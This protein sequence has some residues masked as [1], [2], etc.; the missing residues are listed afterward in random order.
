MAYGSPASLDEVEG[1]YTHIRRGNAPTAEQLADLVGRYQ[2]IGGVSTLRARTE[3]QCS[4][5]QAALDTMAPGA[6]EV[7]LGMKHA[8]PLIEDAID[9]IADDDFERVVAAVLAPHFSRGSVGEYLA[10]AGERADARG[11]ALATVERWY[12]LPEHHAFLV[13]AVR[14]A[15]AALPAATKVFFTA[16]SLPL[17]V[18]E[19]DP[20]ASELEAGAQ[21][22]ADSLGLS[23]FSEWA[24]CWQSAGRTPEPWA[25]PDILA[26]I[27]ALGE[28]G[29]AE[30]V[31]VCPHGFVADHLEVA[32]DLDIEAQRVAAEV[33]LTF[34]RTRTV[35][36]DP[37]VMG[38][39]A[40]RI[41]AAAGDPA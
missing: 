17:R 3:A 18:L 41:A 8:A 24:T 6:F 14:D 28:T 19:G 1:Y 15:R 16:H 29:R 22:V 21:A 23:P 39:L 30:G 4:A 38:A 31:L 33:G 35:N 37:T 26:M 2:A 13:D 27:R 20:Y 40:A 12:D 25:G 34:A 5:I 10:R 9:A 36:D 7:R 11:L 32:Y